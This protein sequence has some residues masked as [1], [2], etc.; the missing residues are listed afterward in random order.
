M[1]TQRLYSLALH[2]LILLVFVIKSL[3]PQGFMPVIDA[4]TAGKLFP[5]TI[6]TSYGTDIVYVTAD[7]LHEDLSTE[8]PTPHAASKPC[9]FAL[10]SSAVT[11]PPIANI[12]LP[13]WHVVSL[14]AVSLGFV[15]KRD[16]VFAYRAQAPPL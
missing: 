3:I 16:V 4:N 8:Q 5:L 12:I 10:L 2:S 15:P 7:K 11:L 13:I 1:N 6:C 9:D 14:A